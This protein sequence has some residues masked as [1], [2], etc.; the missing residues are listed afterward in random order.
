MLNE[1]LPIP[2]RQVQPEW[3][4]CR[5]EG[6]SNNFAVCLVEKP[7]MCP[8]VLPFGRGY[9]CKHPKRAEIIARTEELRKHD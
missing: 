1:Q 5:V 9:L 6:L 8:H 2:I 7:R 4:E 3:S